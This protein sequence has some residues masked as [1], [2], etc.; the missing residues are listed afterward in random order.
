MVGLTISSMLIRTRLSGWIAL[1]AD[2]CG[3]CC[4]SRRSDRAWDFVDMIINAGQIN[5]SRPRDCS[6]R[7]QPGSWR[8]NPDEETTDWR[9]VCGRTARTV[10]RAGTAKAV[11]DPYRF[12]GKFLSL[13]SDTPLA[14]CGVVHFRNGCGRSAQPASPSNLAAVPPRIFCLSASAIFN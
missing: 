12:W 1:Y 4:E 7:L 6:L 9:A 14:F 13:C 8:A 5:S 2:D 3:R 11:P 10:R